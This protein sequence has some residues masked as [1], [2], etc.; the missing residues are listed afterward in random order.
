MENIECIPIEEKRDPETMKHAGIFEAS[1]CKKHEH[2]YC[3]SV[4]K[5]A[6]VNSEIFFENGTAIISPQH[7]DIFTLKTLIIR[8]LNVDEAKNFIRNPTGC[9]EFVYDTTVLSS[10]PLNFL[11]T[12]F[13]VIEDTFIIIQ[14]PEFLFNKLKII[15]GLDKNIKINAHINNPHIVFLKLFAEFSYISHTKLITLGDQSHILKGKT[16][17]T[18]SC[19]V[20]NNLFTFVCSD[21]GKNNN[22]DPCLI[23]GMF[24]KDVRFIRRLLI[25]VDNFSRI[26]YTNLM[27]RALSTKVNSNLYY[28]PFNNDFDYKNMNFECS[29]DCQRFSSVKIYVEFNNNIPQ[30]YNFIMYLL[31]QRCFAVRTNNKIIIYNIHS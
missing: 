3:K 27:M 16:L 29:I 12:E 22:P 13:F 11:F 28:V 19:L 23:R 31:C 10:V 9:V 2:I 21:L 30:P 25:R 14:F 6:S 26:D 8:I 20:E 18:K 15:P 24:I 17:Q 1:V 5:Y 4:N 7:G